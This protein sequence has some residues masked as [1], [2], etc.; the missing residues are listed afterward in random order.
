MIMSISQRLAQAC[1]AAPGR[2]LIAGVKAYRL[3][4]KPWLGNSCRFEPTCSQYAL[5]ALERHGAIAGSSLAA[6]RILR[7][8]PWCDGGCDEVPMRLPALFTRLGL[9]SNPE[10]TGD[11]PGRTLDT[12][13]PDTAVTAAPRVSVTTAQEIER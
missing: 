12:Y 8:N 13:R 7:C 11:V 2:G 4:L 3:V 9:G 6:W 10:S 1:R 5:T